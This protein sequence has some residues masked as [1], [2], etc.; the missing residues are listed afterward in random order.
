MRSAHAV[1][2][3]VA[4]GGSGLFCSCTPVAQGVPTASEAGVSTID[5][6]PLDCFGL[7]ACANGCSSAPCFDTCAAESTSHAQSLNEALQDCLS[8]M[9]PAVNGGPCASRLGQ[10]CETCTQSVQATGQP[11]AAMAVACV[12]D[13]SGSAGDQ[14][15]TDCNAL[16]ACLE[17]CQ[18][19]TCQDNCF[20]AAS[21]LASQRYTIL[22][23]CLS[24]TCSDADGG[25]CAVWT[26]AACST[27]E[28]TA[29]GTGGA[30]FTEDGNCHNSP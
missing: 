6:G 11:C 30:C 16:S 9:C 28:S 10:G 2:F 15:G 12:D 19:I 27:C 14:T 23:E 29:I 1:A 21:S 7:I 24:R 26:S 13:T 22:S 3:T 17:D 18:S 5:A 4:V 8:L 25:V 20:N